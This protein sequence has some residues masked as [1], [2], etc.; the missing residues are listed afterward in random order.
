MKCWEG[1]QC[2]TEPVVDVFAF[3]GWEA[4]RQPH[5][6]AETGRRRTPAVRGVDPD[7]DAR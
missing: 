2:E 4:L 7:I 6:A 1:T 5:L 3:A